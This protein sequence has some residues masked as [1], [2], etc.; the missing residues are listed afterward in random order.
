MSV[1]KRELKSVQELSTWI[2]EH[3]TSV[4]QPGVGGELPVFAIVRRPPSTGR[5]DWT[6]VDRTS[7]RGVRV[8]WSAG[9]YHAIA[10]A[11]LLF[12]VR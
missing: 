7:P 9:L 8:R 4:P 2:A 3:A 5:A 1:A 6:A 10:R 11:Q 12:D